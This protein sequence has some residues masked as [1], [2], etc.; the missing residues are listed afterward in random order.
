M[1]PFFLS[2]IVFF[3]F[4][5]CQKEKLCIDGII[6]WGGDPAVDGLGWFFTSASLGDKPVKLKNL[7]VEYKINDQPVSV[8]VLKTNEKYQCF[9]A[10]PLEV[11][12]ILQ[13]RKR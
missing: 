13:I 1:K 5:S 10:A 6:Q 3:L 11:Y 2:L 9:C 4:A 7:P 12:S 8:C